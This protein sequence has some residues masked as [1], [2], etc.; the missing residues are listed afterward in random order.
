MPGDR[1]LMPQ[2]FY[3]RVTFLGDGNWLPLNVFPY[4]RA[5]LADQLETSEV[6]RLLKLKDLP[7][8]TLDEVYW[9]SYVNNLL[10]KVPRSRESVPD[11]QPRMN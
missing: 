4:L 2:T 11:P 6:L 8:R 9:F 1:R 5:R 10:N 7:E 3:H